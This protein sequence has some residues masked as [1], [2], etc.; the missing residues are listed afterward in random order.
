MN[1]KNFID[2]HVHVGPEILPRR[3]TTETV[4]NEE[5][6][7]I[8]GIAL[9]NHFYPTTPWIKEL[10]NSEDP[11]LI[12]SVTLNNYV[13]GLNPDAVYAAAKLSDRPIVVWF[14]TI[15]SINFLEKNEYEI[16]SEWV[17]TGFISRPSKNVRGITVIDKKGK[18]TNEAYNVIKAIKENNCI[19]ATGHISWQE[20]KLVVEAAIDRGIE[21]IIVTHPV[22]NAIAMPLEVQNALAKNEGVYIEQNYAMYAI[23]KIP[24]ERIAESITLV[25]AENCIM[26]SDMG[27]VTSPKPSEALKRFSSFLESH[28]I[29]RSDIKKMG[30]LNPRRLIR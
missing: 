11:L 13:G 21:K 24:I 6:G 7:N 3:F 17:G 25:K 2:L 5:R 22:Y 8:R 4:S 14:P 1:I 15:N 19:L 9:K 28:G 26:V 29:Q 30:E 18:L 20:A 10:K 16:P 12:G 23:D 27:Q